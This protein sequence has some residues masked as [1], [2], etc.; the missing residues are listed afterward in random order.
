MCVMFKKYGVIK[1]FV[2]WLVD[3]VDGVIRMI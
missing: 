3:V 2:E 1:I